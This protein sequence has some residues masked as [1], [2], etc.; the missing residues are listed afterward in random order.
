MIVTAWNN[1]AHN[2]NGSGYGFRVHPDDRDTYF[3]KEWDKIYLEIEGEEAPVEVQ[4]TAERLWATPPHEIQCAA[5]G[6]WLRK[7]GLA[8]WRRGA[9]PVFILDPLQDN[10]FKVEKAAKRR[11]P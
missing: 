11:S 2:R 9:E 10:H 4:I 6:H 5:L 7:Q 8:P 3:K 1:G